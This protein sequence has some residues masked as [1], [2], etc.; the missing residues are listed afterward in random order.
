MLSLRLRLRQSGTE[1]GAKLSAF[2]LAKQ[3]NVAV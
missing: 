3:M 2:C 1:Q